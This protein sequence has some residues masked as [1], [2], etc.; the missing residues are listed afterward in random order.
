MQNKISDN[1]SG[2]TLLELL[3]YVAVLSIVTM[4]IAGAFLSITQGRARVEAASEVNANLRFAIE[5]IGQDIRGASAVSLPASAGATSTALQLT[6]SGTAVNYCLAD[7]AVRR[8]QGGACTGA[9]EAIT[10]ESVVVNSL[11][12]SR[13]ENTNTTLGKTVLTISVAADMSYDS[14][15]P[16]W[17]YNATKQTTASLP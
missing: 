11:L 2:F 9:S 16:E 10:T 8:Q 7:T 4:V 14:T 3:I 13:T 12:F 6:I 17:Q 5:R 15:A 1:Q